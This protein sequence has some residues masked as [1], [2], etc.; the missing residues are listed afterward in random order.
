MV[1]WLAIL[2]SV[3]TSMQGETEES[4]NSEDSLVS[5]GS[6]EMRIGDSENKEAE[7]FI[8][9]SSPDQQIEENIINR[10][11]TFF[12]RGIWCGHQKHW[13]PRKNFTIAYDKIFFSDSNMKISDV[14]LDIITGKILASPWRLY[15]GCLLKKKI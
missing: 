9:L 14:P 12:L 10:L 1:M 7:Q 13:S 15:L 5:D 2:T 11:K 4:L 3:I 8:T 6:A